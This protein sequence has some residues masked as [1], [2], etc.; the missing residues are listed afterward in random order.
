V[1]A[2]RAAGKPNPASLPAALNLGLVDGKAAVEELFVPQMPEELRYLLAVLDRDLVVSVWTL[3][4]GTEERA[5][6]NRNLL[7][8][9]G[10]ITEDRDNDGIVETS[11]VYQNG[12]IREYS[13]DQDQD[14]LEDLFVRFAQ[15]LPSEAEIAL[16]GD[17]E[18]VLPLGTESRISALLRW[19]RYPAV[20]ATE[21]EGQRYIPRPLDYFYTPFRFVALVPVNGNASSDTLVF[22]AREDPLPVLSEKSL[23]SFAVILEQPSEEFKGGI[24]RIELTDGL[25]LTSSVILEGKIVA[26]TEY[27][28]GRT[29]IQYI[30][31]DLDG[32]METV[33][34]YDPT[35]PYR[36][37]VSESDWDGDGIFEYAETFQS[38]DGTMKKSW[39]RNR[40]GIRETE[41]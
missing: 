10:V 24:E 7:Q 34:H 39:D 40:D 11:T 8:F 5:Y 17:G 22:P 18:E 12:M 23:L 6:L 38:D 27:R 32:R 13:C 29:Y 1:A 19:E 4:R 20:L 36:V 2:Y 9:S 25:P 21:L 3:L 41:E 28:L 33:W 31:L 37:V 26:R 30:D 15:G 14:G 16:A 35:V